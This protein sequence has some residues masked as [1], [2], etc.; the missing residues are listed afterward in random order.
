MPGSVAPWFNDNQRSPYSR[1]STRMHGRTPPL[2]PDPI[3]FASRR[4]PQAPANKTDLASI[5]FSGGPYS[6]IVANRAAAE[7]PKLCRLPPLAGRATPYPDRAGAPASPGCITRSSRFKTPRRTI[8]RLAVRRRSHCITVAQC[9]KRDVSASGHRSRPA[10]WRAGGSAPM[11]VVDPSDRHPPDCGGNRKARRRAT[12][13]SG[14]A[15][16][17]GSGL[18]PATGST[19][20]CSARRVGLAG[21]GVMLPGFSLSDRIDDHLGAPVGEEARAAGCSLTATRAACRDLGCLGLDLVDLIRPMVKL[22][23][24]RSR[25]PGSAGPGGTGISA[26]AHQWGGSRGPLARR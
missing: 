4:P 17:A 14:S 8:R 7:P 2:N 22:R 12:V 26:F 25:G 5:A 16:G 19:R 6:H 21:L 3:S 11:Y 23:V 1:A 10:P 13:D 18:T 15:R 9:R 20:R 24:V